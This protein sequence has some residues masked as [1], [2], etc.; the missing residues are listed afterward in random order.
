MNELLKL[1]EYITG[2]IKVLHISLVGTKIKGNIIEQQTII[3]Q[4][5]S[6]ENIIKYI[7]EIIGN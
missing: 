6:Y 4:I 7:D 1:R 3:G 2:C 5:M